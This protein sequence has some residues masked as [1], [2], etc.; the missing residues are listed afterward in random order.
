MKVTVGQQPITQSFVLSDSSI[1]IILP[2][3]ELQLFDF[4][5]NLNI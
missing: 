4:L 1:R 2:V 5:I 3:R